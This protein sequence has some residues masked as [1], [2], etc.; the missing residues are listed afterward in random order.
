MSAFRFGDATSLADTCDKRCRIGEDDAGA[1]PQLNPSFV[2]VGALAVDPRTV[3][4]A[5]TQTTRLLHQEG[6]SGRPSTASRP[7]ITINVRGSVPRLLLALTPGS[8]SRPKASRNDGS[9][10]RSNIDIFGEHVAPIAPSDP[11]AGRCN[12][13]GDCSRQPWVGQI[14]LRAGELADAPG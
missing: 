11:R 2:L 8:N 1:G 12:D 5:A 10:V 14:I 13:P 3:V 4:A 6:C 9:L 7:T